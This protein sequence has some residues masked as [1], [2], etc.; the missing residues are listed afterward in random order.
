VFQLI[1]AVMSLG[2]VTALS[3]TSIYYGGKAFEH[4]RAVASTRPAMVEPARNAAVDTRPYTALPGRAGS[5]R[6]AEPGE[7]VTVGGR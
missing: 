5:A 7:F 1:T 6:A 3:I 2:L 4:S